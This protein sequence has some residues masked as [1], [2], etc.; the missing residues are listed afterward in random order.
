MIRDL[1]EKSRSYRGYDQSRRVSRDE[2]LQLVDCARLTPSSVNRQPLRYYLACTPE[3]TAKIQPLTHWARAL[4]P[5]QLPHPGHCPP[6]FIIICQDTNVDS[7]LQ[8]YQRD[9]GIVAQT[10]LLVAVEKGLGGCMIGNFS[11]AEVA[12]A[13]D[14]KPNLVPMLV[15]AIGKPDETIILT[16]V[17]NDDT[18]YYRDENDVH[19]VPKRRLEDLIIN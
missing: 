18:N 2:L 3:Q 19:Y 8:R 9:V 6:A 16:E 7:S 4:Q 12:K 13:L 17:K 11:P 1:V 14:L 10:M 5:I 15:V